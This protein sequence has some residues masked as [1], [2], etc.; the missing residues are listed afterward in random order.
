V[1][2]SGRAYFFEGENLA[3][4]ESVVRYQHSA[5]GPGWLHFSNPAEIYSTSCIGDVKAR[6]QAVEDAIR[7]GGTAV[8]FLS[9]ESS[10]AFDANLP[11]SKTTNLPLL[12]FGIFHT[13]PKFYR[14]LLPVYEA[15]KPSQIAYEWDLD[16]YAERFDQVKTALGQ[17]EVYQVNLS[18]RLQ[19]Q[20]EE[21]LFTQFR[22]TCGTQPPPYATFI[23]GEDWQI[24]SYS[25]ELFLQ[26]VGDTV[27]MIP[28]KG[29]RREN[30]CDL[31]EMTT[32]PKSLA[33]NLMIVDMVRN[34]LGKVARVGSV[35]TPRL[36]EVEAHRT[37]RQMV[38]EIQAET[39]VSFCD[40]ITATFPPASVTG[41]PK[42]AACQKIHQLEDS[43][44]EIYCGTI[45]MLQPSGDARFSVAIRTAWQSSQDPNVRYGIGGGLV[46]DSELAD[47]FEE[48]LLKADILTRSAPQWELIEC[49]H[50][51]ALG[52]P[53]LLEDH[54]LRF[55]ASALALHVPLDKASFQNLLLPFAHKA[56]ELPIKIRIAV[57]L[58]GSLS[59]T[60]SDST[61]RPESLRACLA[62]KPI[63]RLDPNMVHK[64]NSRQVL[65]QAKASAHGFDEVLLFNERHEVCEFSRGNALFKLDGKWFT[66]EPHCGCLPGV[67]VSR[68]VRSCEAAY[69]RITVAEAKQ[70]EAI[71]FVNSIVGVLPVT[72]EWQG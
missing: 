25:P 52:D 3:R 55:Q 43:A 63:S 53:S 72:M 54:W 40:L 22:R 14:E 59:V 35:T 30:Q 12:W 70:C 62:R 5:Y 67:G 36:F 4:G 1:D 42:V 56:L 24:A 51:D 23:Q 26:R 13:P 8:G 64:T 2:L 49:F 37:V 39:T 33:E 44:R 16:L 19:L 9:Y 15:S 47:E 29:T 17:G 57:G 41:A 50:R 66:P 69:R 48:C 28:M 7:V 46:W 18:S 58:D 31:P 45:G 10:S 20:S 61:M 71:R 6:V 11:P 65:D 68:L 32:D 21:T 27:T 34:D 60:A 38:S